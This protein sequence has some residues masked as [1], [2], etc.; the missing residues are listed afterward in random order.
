[1]DNHILQL[2]RQNYPQLTDKALQE[3]IARVGKV[4]QFKAHTLIQDYDTYIKLVPLVVRGSIKV[5]RE[6]EEGNELLLYYLSAGETCSMS[7]S[8]CMTNKKS[9]IRTIAE[10]DI[11]VVGIPIR[12]MD[13]W[14]S[15]YTSWRNFVMLSYDNRMRELIKTIDSIAFKELDERLWTYLKQRSEAINSKLIQTTHQG[16]AHD[17]NASREAISRLLKSL[18][19]QGKVALARNKIQLI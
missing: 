1:M 10:D 3:D 16:I 6:D 14:M 2:I 11:T 8:C 15:R 5:L 4:L 12:Y 13:E 18:E 17:L 19:K 7:F 9:D